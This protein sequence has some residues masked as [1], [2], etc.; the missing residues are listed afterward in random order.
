MVNSPSLATA[1]KVVVRQAKTA[2]SKGVFRS[3][4]SRMA[5]KS[6]IVHGSFGAFFDFGGVVLSKF[7]TQVVGGM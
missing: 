6:S 5:T 7:R 2:V 1:Q 4:F 3:R